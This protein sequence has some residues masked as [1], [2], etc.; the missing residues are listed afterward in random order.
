MANR[1]TIGGESDAD[2]ISKLIE[3]LSN[4]EYKI[5]ELESKQYD[6]QISDLEKKVSDIKSSINPIKEDMNELKPLRD[7]VMIAISDL[8]TLKRDISNILQSEPLVEVEDFT[9]TG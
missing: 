1:T 3:K 2:K 9:Y 7:E 5:K 4:L 6:N 8:E